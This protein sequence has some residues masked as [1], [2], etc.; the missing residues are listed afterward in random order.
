[1]TQ[2]IYFTHKLLLNF[3]ILTTQLKSKLQIISV[4]TN[5]IPF[6]NK[7]WYLILSSRFNFNSPLY[8]SIKIYSLS[9]PNNISHQSNQLSSNHQFTTFITTLSTCWED[10]RCKMFSSVFSYFPKKINP[11]FF[12]Q[13]MLHSQTK[14][15]QNWVCKKSL[16]TRQTA[17]GMSGWVRKLE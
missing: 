6:P 3:L 16:K 10:I 4:R 13:K 2:F 5:S 11:K 9:Q 14:H 17:T 1:M 7:I 15:L 8:I 12:N